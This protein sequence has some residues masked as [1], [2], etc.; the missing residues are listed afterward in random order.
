MAYTG[1]R[2]SQIMRLTPAAWDPRRRLLMVPGTDKGRGTK[3]YTL[4]LG[5]SATAA[6]QTFDAREAWGRFTW[7]PMARMW[8]EAW[9]A[10]RTGDDRLAIR[11]HPA[12]YAHI[13]T[14]VPYD[15]R[16]SFGTQL[17]RKT[18]D[19]KAVKEL[20]GHASIRMT[21]RYTLAAVSEQKHKAM[22]AFEASVGRKLPPRVAP[23][24]TLRTKA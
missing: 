5:R 22:Q 3:P 20:L 24:R 21:E 1:L 23:P 10:M 6:L 14:P 15:L 19:L 11:A 16:H 7:A 17:Y 2:Q 18:G 9:L 13:E 12:A 4:P 8:R